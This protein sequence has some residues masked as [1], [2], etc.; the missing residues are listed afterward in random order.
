MAV[1]K[2]IAKRLEIPQGK[3]KVYNID[4]ESIAICNLNGGFYAF[5]NECP[6]MDFPL[7]RGII[8]GETITCPAH[9][10]RFNIKTGEVLSMPA[11][12]P[13][14]TYRVNVEGDDI[15]IEMD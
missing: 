1:R 7:T 9:G 2:K 14:K 13:L 8:M 4:G 6:H 3:L 5:K 15:I 10:S 11:A 12:Y